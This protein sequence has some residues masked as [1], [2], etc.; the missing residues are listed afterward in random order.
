MEKGKGGLELQ[1]FGNRRAVADGCDGIV[2]YGEGQVVLRAG[3]LWVKLTGEGLLP[4][5]ADLPFRRGGGENPPGG[6]RLRGEGGRGDAGKARAFSHRLGPGG[7][8]GKLGQVSQRGGP[9]RLGILGFPAAGGGRP[10]LLPGPVLQAA[11]PPG[12]AVGG[13]A[14]AAGGGAGSPFTQPG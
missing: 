4:G 12:P 11:A 10:G 3:R 8:P 13:A 5:A 2:D 9:V 7:G 14:A 6:V 1:V